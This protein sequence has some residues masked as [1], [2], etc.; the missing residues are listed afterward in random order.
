MR[1]ATHGR[2]QIELANARDVPSLPEVERRACDLFLQV[3]FTAALPALPTP[4]LAFERAR[5]EGLLWVARHA[6]G[7]PVGFAL[8]Q[9]L[10]PDF[11]LEELDVLPEHGRRGLGTA[12]VH[13]VCA[14]AERQAGAAVTLCTFREIPWNA[15]FYERHGFNRLEP[16]DLTPA[17]ERRMRE[18]AAR[19]L[20][21]EHRVA[22]RWKAG[23]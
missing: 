17:L 8:V 20:P 7:T 9:R 4:L 11:H 12:L 22:M 19:G 2:Y 18:E 1:S 15:P 5:R 16:G 10:G 21:V 14:W 3:P 6:E 13:A 23:P